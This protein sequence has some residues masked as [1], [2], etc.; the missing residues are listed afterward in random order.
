MR[1]ALI[2][3]TTYEDNPKLEPHRAAPWD[4]ALM[5]ERL[6]NADLDFIV[7]RL[8]ADRDLPER[9]EA[10]FE[11]YPGDI[12]ALAV[13]FSGYVAVSEE[14]GPALLLSGSRLKAFPVSRLKA[15]LSNAAANTLCVLD[16]AIMAQGTRW[17]KDIA[18]ELAECLAD[19]EHGL[20]ALVSARLLTSPRPVGVSRFTDLLD[21]VLEWLAR[22]ARGQITPRELLEAM[23]L[24]RATFAQVAATH[25]VE[26]HV[27]FPLMSGSGAEYLASPSP[28]P[29]PVERPP[30]QQE[31]SPKPPPR[32]AYM[33][34]APPRGQQ[35]TK[36]PALRVPSLQAPADR[37]PADGPAHEPYPQMQTEPPDAQPWRQSAEPTPAAPEAAAPRHRTAEVNPVAQQAPAP[38]EPATGAGAAWST[39]P[40]V[41]GQD[42]ALPAPSGLEGSAIVRDPAADQPS[43]SAF[44]AEPPQPRDAFSSEPDEITDVTTR[45]DLDEGEA[46]SGPQ[47]MVWPVTNQET[48]PAPDSGE[49]STTDADLAPFNALSAT[50]PQPP[51]GPP[52]GGAASASTTPGDELRTPAL[53]AP[54]PARAEPDLAEPLPPHRPKLETLPGIQPRPGAHSTEDEVEGPAP[55]TRHLRQDVPAEA[56]AAAVLAAAQPE[57]ERD[58]KP[59]AVPPPS[60]TPPR[61]S[62]SPEPSA[63]APSGTGSPE[64]LP[65]RAVVESSSPP[66]PAG[67]MGQEEEDEPT[68][69]PA[70]SRPARASGGANAAGPSVPPVAVAIYEQALQAL[71]PED[72]GRPEIHIRLANAA[73]AEGRDEAVLEHLL[74]AHALE[75]LRREPFEEMVNLLE[76]KGR[77]EE[78]TTLCRER[79]NH[80]YEDE[81]TVALLDKLVT[82]WI[83]RRNDPAEALKTLEERLAFRAD[84]AGLQRLVKLHDRLGDHDGA[85][86]ALEELA[87]TIEEPG[88]RVDVLIDAAHQADVVLGDLQRAVRLAKK[89]FAADPS[90]SVAFDL[91]VSGLRSLGD[92][93]GLADLYELALEH[94]PIEDVAVRLINDLMAVCREHLKDPI[95]IAR[96]A[97][98]AMRLAPRRV[99]LR[100]TL[101][102]AYESRGLLDDAL[103]QVRAA[104]TLAPTS[105]NAYR[106]ARRLMDAAGNTDGAFAAASITRWLDPSDAEAVQ[107]VDAH[108]SPGLLVAERTLSDEDWELLTAEMH[109][110]LL[111]ALDAIYDAA[112]TLLLRGRGR[113]PVTLDPALRHPPE[114]TA[115]LARTVHWAGQLLRVPMPAVYIMPE[116]EEPLSIPQ[117]EEPSLLLGRS[118]ATG[119]SL[120]ELAFLTGR[121]LALFRREFYLL[122]LYGNARD[123]AEPLR[124]GLLM[125]A[126]LPVPDDADRATAKAF[127]RLLTDQDLE[128][129]REAVDLL[130]LDL[131]ALLEE[132][133][134]AVLRTATR[135]GVLACGHPHVVGEILERYPLYG[136]LD[137]KDQQETIALFSMSDQYTE[138]RRR[139]GVGAP[140]RDSAEG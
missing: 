89:A 63:S 59:L 111:I 72:L 73:R 25:L 35:P 45:P 43:V 15:L 93:E 18:R 48:F 12:E 7:E 108:G 110:S 137:L 123:L 55:P 112:R 34:S 39:P 125:A 46:H 20:N 42:A 33:A 100:I 21:L 50:E 19:V 94:E 49:T 44:G 58:E 77:Y 60:R 70:V 98:R 38:D 64:T 13:Y 66:P 36:M 138:L 140:P 4:S 104:M 86:A 8:D 79:L 24:E 83:E 32:L 106:V 16:A 80:V 47:P 84:R 23:K 95:R 10:L 130:E 131:E 129:L 74:K 99:D 68:P 2:I 81:E 102:E 87:A 56:P 97:R 62:A 3:S 118:L 90:S 67:V 27:P 57:A 121:H 113:K 120:P 69:M 30:A 128:Q 135:A 117:T 52:L 109:S 101:A 115:T 31:K 76:S 124:Y 119:H 91:A 40:V 11:R 22:N 132:W 65:S 133:T 28:E 5:A 103:D 122:G 134:A 139:L 17:P 107:Y 26:A 127:Q 126:N 82:V 61:E 78:V 29:R 53:A 116:L 51:T 54:A 92:Q 1:L 96:A 41:P 88:E 105:P 71:S 14:R 6:M 75:Q 37:V 136:P 9:L 114:S 85:V